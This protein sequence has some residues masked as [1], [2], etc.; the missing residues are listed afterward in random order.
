MTTRYIA[1]LLVTLLVTLVVSERC[2]A[3]GALVRKPAQELFEFL[4]K[5]LG[6]EGA[7]E[8][9]AV[10]GREGLQQLLERAAR[11][12][13]E[14]LVQ[15]VSQYGKTY[16]V[17]ALRVIDRAPSQLVRVMDDLP[18]DL[19]K[20]AL[21]AVGRDPERMTQLVRQYGKE[22]LEAEMAH[23]GLGAKFVEQVGASGSA[24]AKRIP[25]DNFMTLSRHTDEITFL[26]G[27]TKA[28]LLNALKRAPFTILAYL[29][30]HPKVTITAASA[31][32]LIT[33]ANQSGEYY[34]VRPDGTQIYKKRSP[35]DIVVDALQPAMTKV[36]LLLGGITALGLAYH[37]GLG[38]LMPWAK[39]TRLRRRRRSPRIDTRMPGSR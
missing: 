3:Q 24:I 21:H 27:E 22:V 5:K 30:K 4:A 13:G 34:E 15:K 18:P 32:T 2:M 8:L 17:Q 29:E 39:L 25:T 12:G 28:Q 35:V 14:T 23:P 26:P 10:G 9:A 7:Q 33:I 1:V 37:L 36:I 38:N 31:A 20:P 19:I 11:E 6:K 16:G